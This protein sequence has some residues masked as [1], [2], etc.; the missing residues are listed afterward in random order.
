MG[1]ASYFAFLL[2]H[3]SEIMTAKKADEG[4]SIPHNVL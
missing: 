4:L 1:H 3:Y 2:G